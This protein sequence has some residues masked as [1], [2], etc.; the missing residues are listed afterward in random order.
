MRILLI[1]F[2]ILSFLYEIIT[3]TLIQHQ[4]KKPL[5]KEVADIYPADRYQTF[6]AYKKDLKPIFFTR[7][8]LST[9]ASLIV[10]ISPFYSL[11]DHPNPYIGWILTMLV[12]LL[13]DQLIDLPFDYYTTFTIENRYEL[14]HRTKKEFF[15]DLLISNITNGIATLLLGYLFVYICTHI[16][17][18][19]HHFA[20][21]YTES[22]LFC[23]GLAFVFFLLFCI[24]QLIA[25][26]SMRL[27]YHFHELEEGKLRQQ[28]WEFCKESKKKVRHI[29]IYDESKK[30][31]SRNAFLLSFLGYREFGI[32]DNFILQNKTDE[33]YAVLLH[34]IG[35]L[36]HKKNIWNWLQYVWIV[37]FFC[38]LVWLIP[39]AHVILSLNEWILHDF[40]LEYTNYYLS[41]SCFLTLFK[42]ILFILNL[43]RNYVSCKEENEADNNA[44]QHGYGNAL[45]QTFKTISTDE[46]I[47]VNPH[48]IIEFLEYDHPGM[49]RRI[50][51]I[52]KEEK[53]R[54]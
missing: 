25:L 27:Q 19:T 6:L 11:L 9:C 53:K 8:I 3:Y 32:A 41:L 38:F 39:N 35:H 42:P 14:N 54:S 5:P 33:L 20:I 26:G 21:S 2:T 30:S 1:V 48:P 23:L 43:Y 4:R 13:I 50:S 47:D 52:L 49:Y 15:K 40:H 51:T 22:F 29:K 17:S 24:L 44:V 46:L 7:S 12:I 37:C 16:E 34:E 18:W 10:L 28:I 31:N 36:K 45:I